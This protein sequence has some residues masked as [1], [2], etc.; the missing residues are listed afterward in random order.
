MNKNEKIWTVYGG[1]GFV[2][3]EFCSQFKDEIIR[4]DK[5]DLVP[6]TNH[7]IYGISTVDN[8]NIF[9][10]PT[11]DIETNLIRLIETLE[12][13]QNTFGKDFEFVFISS[14]FVYG[15]SPCSKEQP[16]REE[17]YCNPTGFYSITKRAAEQLLISYC[18]TYGIKYKILRL[19]NVL[20]AKD[21]KVSKKKNALQYLLKAITLNE[22]VELYDGGQFYRDL[23]DVRDCAKAIRFCIDSDLP[24][25]IFNVSN[26]ESFRFHDLIEYAITYSGSKS[27][28]V[29]KVNKPEFHSVVQSRDAFIDNTRLKET[30]YSPKFTIWE[31]IRRIIDDYTG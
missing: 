6:K 2:L 28:I 26:G 10:A 8:Y 12:S 4:L 11:L 14:W 19:A 23:I 13:C 9:D 3:G 30:G 29:D 7:I 27:F 1:H 17:S 25:K 22:S 31:T 16:W 24:H 18:E 5:L 21:P 15:T 20:G